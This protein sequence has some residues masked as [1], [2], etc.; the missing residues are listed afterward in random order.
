[1][2]TSYWSRVLAT[3]ANRR[4][5]LTV[6]GGSLLGAIILAACGGGGQSAGLRFDDAGTARVP[7]TVWFSK[8]DWKLADETKQ[9]VKG[10]IYRG[11]LDADRAGHFDAITLMSS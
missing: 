6:T 11:L 2:A 8:N 5:T 7:G 4:R 9:A 10:G 1:M 3:Q